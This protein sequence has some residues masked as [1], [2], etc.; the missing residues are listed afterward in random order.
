MWCSMSRTLMPRRWTRPDDL[1]QLDHVRVGE[2]RGGLIQDEQVG[3]AGQ[4][5]GDLQKR[6]AP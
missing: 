2:A 6:W 5:A 4:G 3:L 1:D